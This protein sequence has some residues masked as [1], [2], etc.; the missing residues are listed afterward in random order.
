MH[1]YRHID[2]ALQ[3]TIC[4]V[5]VRSNCNNHLYPLSHI[6]AGVSEMLQQVAFLTCFP[7]RISMG[8][9]VPK[10]FL[11]YFFAT[12]AN[13]GPDETGKSRLAVV[14]LTSA[15]SPLLP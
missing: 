7:F 5:N 11:N 8:V 10:N 14:E 15:I 4:K 13:R 1:Q 2:V 3:K 6:L 9:Q 12:W